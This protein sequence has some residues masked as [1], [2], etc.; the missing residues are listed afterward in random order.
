MYVLRFVTI[1]GAS[2][3]LAA[4]AAVAP[5]L[6]T[7]HS[8]FW[9]IA[10]VVGVAANVT[11]R[12]DAAR[13]WLRAGAGSCD[14]RPS[15]CTAETLRDQIAGTRYNVVGRGWGFFIERRAPP[16]PRMH[17]QHFR[18]PMPGYE[19]MRPSDRR[20]AAG[21]TIRE[22]TDAL[23]TENLTF[24]SH[25][26]QDDISIGSWF[27][28]G[29]H[30]NGGDRNHGSSHAFKNATVLDME[31]GELELIDSYE[32]LRSR[33]DTREGSNLVIVDVLFDR[34]HL[35]VDYVLQKQMIRVEGP[36]S[37]REWLRA[38]AV[39]RVLFVGAARDYGLGV[40]W[41]DL[42]EPT[43]HRDPHC[44]SRCCTFLQADVCSVVCGCHEPADKWSGLVSLR[45]AN[46]WT[47]P[48]LAAD[49]V[50]VA[51]GGLRNFELIFRARLDADRLWRLVRELRA[52]HKRH[53][54]RSEIRH[55]TDIV[56]VD[57]VLGRAFDAPLRAL[58]AL[59]VREFAFHPGKWIPPV[60]VPGLAR[61]TLGMIYFQKLTIR[62]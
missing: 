35:V 23:W 54:G 42:Y 55:G 37:A 27:A 17:L 36:D 14:F 60:T 41:G 22:V 9:W 26:T 6:A 1:W 40:R 2:Y 49:T 44:C 47:P 12:L 21:T 19:A 61:T 48:L 62:R 13:V 32:T 24:E 52:V 33:F 31:R 3:A 38:G 28:R 16:A 50:L 7:T 57:V 18:G 11:I 8:P 45:D 39:L 4:L 15:T 10:C 5:V 51:L 58:E 25:P 34:D 56:F 20:W 46:R 29:S 30:G 53:G 43:D 59:D